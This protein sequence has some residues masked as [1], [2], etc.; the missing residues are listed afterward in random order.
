MKVADVV[1]QHRGEGTRTSP[2]KT[3]V[4]DSQSNGMIE[5]SNK[6][7]EAQ[8]RTLLCSL[9]RKIGQRVAGDW[10]IFPWAIIHPGT[11][12]NRFH[13]PRGRDGKT[14]YELI[15]GRKSKR[16]ML[17][18]GKSVHFIPGSDYKAIPKAEPRGKIGTWIGIGDDTDEHLVATA[19]GIF[20]TRTVRRR[21]A[22]VRWDASAINTIRGLPWTPYRET[23]DDTTVTE[24]EPDNIKGPTNATA[25]DDP[26][27]PPRRFRITK[28]HLQQYQFTSAC[29]GC[30]AARHNRP[31]REHTDHCRQRIRK[32]IE[33]GPTNRHIAED[34]ENKESRWLEK[35][36][37]AA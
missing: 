19:E 15:K 23:T 9:S 4:G 18:F 24:K 21:P 27:T 12:I 10:D 8:A 16:E 29:P 36:N 30:Y 26:N 33:N 13:V 28:A 1:A 6:F 31:H 17:E 34:A 32:A 5:N 22:D 14:A 2:E 11:L 37:Y 3:P 7:V 25:T 35:T 20:K